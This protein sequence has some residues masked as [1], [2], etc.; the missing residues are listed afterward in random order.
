MTNRYLKTNRNKPAFNW[1]AVYRRLDALRAQV[2]EDWAPDAQEAN[3]LLEARAALLARQP[4]QEA[5][6]RETL[7]IVEFVLAYERYGVQSTF[8]REVWPLESITR[9]PCV[10]SFVLGIINV[11]G[12]VLSVVDVKRFFDLPE[13]G[14]TDLNKVIVLESEEMTFGVLADSVIGVRRL[15]VDALQPSLPT[16]TGIRSEYLQGIAPD[17]TVVLD[18]ARLL[19]DERIVVNDSVTV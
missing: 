12:E 18:A 15:A 9:I 11:R 13:K 3:R 14:L 17:R 10:P 16:L 7:E 19:S 5:N 6:D 4:M 1:E 2:D 8:V